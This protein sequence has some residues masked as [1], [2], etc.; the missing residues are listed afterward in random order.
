MLR[1]NLREP[2][3]TAPIPDRLNVAQPTDKTLGS[4]QESASGRDDY[5]LEHNNE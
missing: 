1:V 3:Q 5:T 4:I 2:S